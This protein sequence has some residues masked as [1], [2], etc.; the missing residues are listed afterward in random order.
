MLVPL[1]AR[2]T[3]STTAAAARVRLCAPFLCGT[4]RVTTTGRWVTYF[5]FV[6]AHQKNTLASDGWDGVFKN[7]T[8]KAQRQGLISVCISFS[9]TNRYH[10]DGSLILFY[11]FCFLS[12]CLSYLLDFFSSLQVIQYPEDISHLMFRI[13]HSHT[14]THSFET[15]DFFSSIFVLPRLK[16]N[17]E[18]CQRC[19]Y[20]KPLQIMNQCFF[21]PTDCFNNGN[22]FPSNRFSHSLQPSHK[23]HLKLGTLGADKKN[24]KQ[25]RRRGW[26][27][28]RRS[29]L[30]LAYSPLVRQNKVHFDIEGKTRQE[31]ASDV[32]HE[33]HTCS[34][35]EGGQNTCRTT[36]RSC[37]A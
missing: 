18:T 5:V 26:W 15:L 16:S 2:R 24:C 37:V 3:A 22:F 32:V 11:F 35:K 30:Y 7:S 4:R 12:I 27:N 36:R 23:L 10:F 17:S 20:V 1:S 33:S 28:G 29:W 21:S 6:C 14:L 31:K 8:T 34:R 25:A 9:S 19:C 13:T